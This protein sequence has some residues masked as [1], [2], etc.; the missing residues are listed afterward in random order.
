MNAVAGTPDV[1][2]L[3]K[4]W[5]GE[6]D[7]LRDAHGLA[8]RFYEKLHWRL[9][10]PT[11]IVTAI[12]GAFVWT[13]SNPWTRMVDSN[14]VAGLLSIVV[15]VLNAAQTFL[16]TDER[17]NRHKNAHDRYDGLQRELQ[18]VVAARPSQEELSAFTADLQARWSKISIEAP[19]LGDA[20]FNKVAGLKTRP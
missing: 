1:F 9:G 7:V 11:V 18:R 19:I 17:S 6:L 10:L 12:L 2:A 4:A 13:E 15:L 5:E 3:I 16:K 20:L 14:L 8:A